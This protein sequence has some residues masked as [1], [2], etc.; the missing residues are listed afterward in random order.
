MRYWETEST[1][2][3][4]LAYQPGTG[5]V[6]FNPS[7]SQNWAGPY[8]NI[9]FRTENRQGTQDVVK[10]GI[11]TDNPTHLLT[12]DGTIKSEEIIVETVGADFV[13]E[14]AYP[15]RPLEAVEAFIAQN[16]HLPDVASAQQMQSEGVEL[17]AFTTLL[18]QKI[19]EL[20]LY[21]IE[22]Q[23]Q[24]EALQ[25]ELSTMRLLDQ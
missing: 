16:G 25:H 19:E 20:T 17:A 1:W 7:E 22:Q 4:F 18:L 14:D 11:G 13:F 6:V 23:K 3:S 15:L 21:T 10:V 9:L 12:V 24:L 2:R 5:S 8:G